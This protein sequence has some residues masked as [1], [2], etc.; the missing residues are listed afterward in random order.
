MSV[1]CLSKAHRSQRGAVCFLFHISHNNKY[2]V[3]K[4]EIKMNFNCFNRCPNAAASVVGSDEF[5]CIRGTVGFY[6]TAILVQK[7][8]AKTPP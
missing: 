6:Q 5:P 3:M 4:G 1:N 2:D 8:S 7:N